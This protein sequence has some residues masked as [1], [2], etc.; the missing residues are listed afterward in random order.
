[1]A[2]DSRTKVSNAV[3]GAS[4][5]IIT[6]LAIFLGMIAAYFVTRGNLMEWPPAGQPRFPVELTFFNTLILIASGV[7]MYLATRT[8]SDPFKKNQTLRYMGIGAALA[9]LFLLIQGTEWVRLITF[10]LQAKSLYGS[11]FYLIIGTHA[12]HVVAALAYVLYVY[13]QVVKARKPKDVESKFVVHKI[14]WYFVVGMWPI[15]YTIMYLM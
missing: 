10:G 15:L 13:V 4:I 7:M 5:F 14:F 11:L 2:I 12:L 3:V 8:F 1:M 9:T 6:E